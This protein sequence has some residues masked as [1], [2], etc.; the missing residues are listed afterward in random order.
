MTQHRDRNYATRHNPPVYSVDELINPVVAYVVDSPGQTMPQIVQ[1]F[2]YV[3]IRTIY[4]VI[5]AAVAQKLVRRMPRRGSMLSIVVPY[6]AVNLK[7]PGPVTSKDGHAPAVWVH[8]IRAR[9]LGLPV[10]TVVRDQ[11]PPDYAHPKQVR[12]A[13]LQHTTMA[14]AHEVL[15]TD[16]AN[17]TY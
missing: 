11:P 5:Q 1:A 8:P 16:D 13:T 10:A 9:A 15:Q 14:T 2:A 6:G 12:A 17:Q 3:P 7:T 4:R